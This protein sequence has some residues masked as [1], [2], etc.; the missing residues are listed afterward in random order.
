M[1]FTVDCNILSKALE[2]VQVKGKGTTSNGFGNTNF[3][4]YADIVINGN[5]L[6]VWNANPTFCAK[7]DIQLEGETIDGTVCVD[8]RTVIPYLKSFGD[9]VNVSVGDFIAMNSDNRKASIPKVVTHPNADSLNRL[10]NMLSHINYEI[11]P[12][13]LFTFGNAKFEGAFAVTQPQLKSAIKNCELVKSGIY[14]FDYNNNILTVSSR[15]NVMNKYEEVITPVFPMGEPA[16]IEF[17]SAIYSFFEADQMLN[18]YMRD[19]FPLLVVSNDRIL[20]KA[21]TINGD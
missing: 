7:V 20:L 6:S 3:G 18:I 19:E 2:S 16:T 13:T 4:T 9:T 15:E 12:Q 21:P 11:Q 10:K 5:N 1:K 8:S 17:S 14:K